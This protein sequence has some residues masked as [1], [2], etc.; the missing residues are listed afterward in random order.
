[1][2]EVE[3]LYRRTEEHSLASRVFQ[4][5]YRSDLPDDTIL[6]GAGATLQVQVVRDN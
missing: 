4:N 2:A 6:I 5:L 1:L 3:S